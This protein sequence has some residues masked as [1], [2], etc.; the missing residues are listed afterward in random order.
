MGSCSA[1]LATSFPAESGFVDDEAQAAFQYL[2]SVKEEASGLPFAVEAVVGTPDR[3]ASSRPHSA[4]SSVVLVEPRLKCAIIEYY[5][6][7]RELVSKS[8][9]EKAEVLI[10]FTP[11][12]SDSVLPQADFSSIA[13]GIEDLSE[14]LHELDLEIVIEWLFGLLLHLDFPLLEDTSAALQATRRFCEDM[15]ADANELDRSKLLVCIVI[16]REHF[17]QM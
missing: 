17:R 12:M 13:A 15:Q 7:L 16:I 9:V 6:S 3:S 5:L 8:A 10:D 11:G 1:V 4:P 2:N 14:L